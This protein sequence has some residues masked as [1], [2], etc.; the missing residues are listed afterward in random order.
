M[1]TQTSDLLRAMADILVIEIEINFVKAGKLITKKQASQV[2][3]N[4]GQQLELDRLKNEN[5]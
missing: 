4:I 5:C 3:I 1:E 2:L